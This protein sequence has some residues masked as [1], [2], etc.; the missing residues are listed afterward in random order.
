MAVDC[1]SPGADI[2]DEFLPVCSG[3]AATRCLLGEEGVPPTERKARTGEL[4]PP[5]MSFFTRSKRGRCVHDE[6]FL[7]G[8][9]LNDWHSPAGAK[10]EG[11]DLKARCC[12]LT[13]VFIAVD[14]GNDFPNHLSSN[15]W[16]MRALMDKP[17]S[18]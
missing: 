14:Q 8:V 7:I 9:F 15:P 16:L 6:N 11:S 17:F 10:C 1:R 4:T 5:G 12:L 18:I 3:Q 2:V 13:L